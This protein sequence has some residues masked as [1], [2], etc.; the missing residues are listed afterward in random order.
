M[1]LPTETKLPGA[2][3]QLSIKRDN[4][5]FL[6]WFP[7]PSLPNIFGRPIGSDKKKKKLK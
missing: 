4:E 2:D 7:I 5:V 3:H 6:Y 1:L